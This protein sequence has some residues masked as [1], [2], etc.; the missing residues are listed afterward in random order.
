MKIPL[1]KNTVTNYVLIALKLLEGFLLVRWI[2]S[3]LGVELYGL[4]GIL[5][6]LLMYAALADFGFG[7]AIRKCTARG[8]WKDAPAHYNRV[9]STLFLASAVMMVP[10]LGATAVAVWKAPLLFHLKDDTQGLITLARW[11]LVIFGVGNAVNFPLT[12][13]GNMIVGLQQQYRQNSVYAILKLLEFVVVCVVF[14][15][16]MPRH[17]AFYA[18]LTLVVLIPVVGNV[19]VGVAVYRLLPGLR[20]T[21]GFDRRAF[22]EVLSFSGWIYLGTLAHLVIGTVSPLL[23]GAFCGLSVAG[24][25]QVGRKFPQIMCQLTSPYQENTSPLAARLWAH[26]K[27]LTLGRV[28]L[29]FMRWNAFI[30]TALSLL[31]FALAPEL[32]RFFFKVHMPEAVAVCRIFTVHMWLQLV[33]STV[34]QAAFLMVERHRFHILTSSTAAALTVGFTI[35]ALRLY[36]G[37]AAAVSVAGLSVA[38]MLAFLAHFPMLSHVTGMS[39]F[40][41]F[42]RTVGAALVAAVPALVAARLG[43]SA[44]GRSDFLR[45]AIGTFFGLGSFLPLGAVLLFTGAEQARFWN[46]TMASVAKLRGRACA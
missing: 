13:F 10:I 33:A 45:L 18:L 16:G 21:C 26:G 25:F 12:L 19:L 2:I 8:L 31:V 7:I 39:C 23:V 36:P 4:W 3:L 9:A 28:L 43:A 46:R 41:I 32:I 22:R 40:M 15:V 27:R 20:M 30:S 34:P 6:G 44:F 5:W 1:L 14:H 35:L 17:A 42:S 29:G 38:A 24:V 11:G 37:S